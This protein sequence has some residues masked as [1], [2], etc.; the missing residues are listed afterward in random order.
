MKRRDIL[1]TGLIGTSLSLTNTALGAPTK[2]PKTPRDAE[3][4]FYPRANRDNDTP[5][6][7]RDMTTPR[8][9]IL[10][11]AGHVMDTDG[12][13]KSGR[14]VDMWHTDPQ[15]RYLHPYDSTPGE[16]FD[17]FAY[18]GKAE[19]DAK[20]AFKFR[21]Y[22]P[23]GYGG[24]PAHIHYIIW[25]GEKR[26]L[27]SQIYFRGL[28]EGTGAIIKSTRHDLRKTDLTERSDGSFDIDFRVVI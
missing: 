17:D 8:G 15:G 22:I 1:K 9:K 7:L 26:E 3:G 23:G 27:T 13:P 10:H 14:I 12:V 19:T 20:G 18:F 21:T 11:F 25:N 28:A 16:R 5:D 24:R 6:L 4:P 2:L